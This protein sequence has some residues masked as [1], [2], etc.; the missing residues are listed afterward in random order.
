MYTC[1][2]IAMTCHHE[3]FLGSPFLEH[4]AMQ[5][6]MQQDLNSLSTIALDLD[7]DNDV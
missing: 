1:S 4:L 6:C 3:I 5:P 7:L 2:S